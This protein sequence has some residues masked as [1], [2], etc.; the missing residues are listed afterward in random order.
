ME[1]KENHLEAFKVNRL[2]WDERVEAHWNSQMYQRHAGELR[3][4][5]PCLGDQIT[6]DMGDVAGLSLA[7]LQCHMGMETLSWAMLGAEVL[8][9]DFSEPAIVKAR[10]LGAELDMNA[11]FVCA[12]VYDACEVV[13]QEF[14]IVFVSVGS[15]VWLPRIDRWAQIVSTLL[16]PG[17]RLYMNEVHPFVDVFDDDSS[18]RR[19][20]VKYP[21]L[22]AGGLASDE[23]GSYADPNAV[24]Q[25][26]KTVYYLHSIGSILN[27]LIQADRFD[28]SNQCTWPRF[29]SMT[30]SGPDQWK[31][32]DQALDRLPH[33]YTLEA[34]APTDSTPPAAMI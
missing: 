28:E 6:R 25:N 27:A 29:K 16:R 30:Q 17:G 15:I 33:T 4:G 19:I 2:S 11:R 26:I 3:S 20:T 12:N 14:D 23:P 10:Q 8:G 22:D 13:R 18:G 34:H 24:F 9:L 5:R 31:F 1:W 32:S 21:Y 7:H